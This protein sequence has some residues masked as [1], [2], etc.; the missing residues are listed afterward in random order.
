MT[1]MQ[2]I[3]AVRRKDR[4]GE[5]QIRRYMK[6]LGIQPLGQAKRRPQRWPEDTAA[7]ILLHLGTGNGEASGRLVTP[8]ELQA[9]RPKAGRGK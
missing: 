3:K 2:V 5:K 6:R 9:L 8:S 1:T 4:I 7:R